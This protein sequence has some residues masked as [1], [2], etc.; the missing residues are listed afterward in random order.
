MNEIRL[1]WLT[2]HGP[3][4]PIWQVWWRQGT[5]GAIVRVTAGEVYTRLGRIERRYYNP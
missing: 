4:H 5:A 3:E 2:L 1:Y